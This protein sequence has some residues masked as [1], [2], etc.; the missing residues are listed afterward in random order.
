M[1]KL[2]G[3]VLAQESKEPLSGLKV[4]AY[5][6]DLLYD[7]LLG[8]AVT[9]EQGEFAM[10]FTEK[11]F[12]ELFESKPDIYL[13]IYSNTFEPIYDTSDCVRWGASESE[14]FEVLIPQDCLP[15][16]P[17]LSNDFVD[18]EILVTAKH[19][20][21]HDVNGYKVPKLP[22]FASDGQPG[23]PAL[24]SQHQ[25]IAMPMGTKAAKIEVT[26]G[27]PIIISGIRNPLPAQEPY[28]DLGSSKEEFE[29]GFTFEDF[30]PEF[31]PLSTAFRK[32]I[33]PEELVTLQTSEDFQLVHMASLKVQPVQYDANKKEYR[34]YPDLKYR[35]HLEADD[36]EEEKPSKREIGFHEAE[37]M[38]QVL[39]MDVVWRVEDLRIPPILIWEEAAHVIITDN[40]EWPESIA[41]ADGTTRAPNINERGVALVG[42][43]IAEYDRLAEWKTAKGMRSK[44]VTISQIVNGQFGDM[45]QNGLARDLQEVIRNFVKYAKSTWK[46]MYVL[47]AGDINVVP[48]RKLCGCSTYGTIGTGTTASNPPENGKCHIIPAK[49]TVKLWPKFTPAA[50]DPLA[51]RNGGLRIPYDSQAGSGR[52]GW[53][54]TTK[55]DF[56]TKDD[57]FE[58]RAANQPTAY[59]IVE[60][61][62]AVIDDSYY[63]LRD[64]NEIPSDFYY[65]SIIGPGYSQPGNHDF[66]LDNNGIYGQYHWS[67]GA[68]VSLDGIDLGSDVFVGRASTDSAAQATA[69][70]NKIIA[71]EKLEDANGVAI[72][73]DYLKKIIYSAALWG[74]WRAHFNQADTT[75]PP[76]EGRFTHE[77]G[78]TET[79]INLNFDVTLAG[80]NP[81]HRMVA[82]TANVDTVIDYDT[83]A[84]QNTLGWFYCTDNTYST[85]SA[86]A[87]RFL[88]IR[89][90]EAD[91]TPGSIVWDAIGMES[92]VVEKE[93]LRIRMN[94]WF[95]AFDQIDRHYDDYF[96]V[97]APPALQKRITANLKAAIDAGCHFLS[98][99]GHGWSGG[100]CG[101]NTNTQNYAN[102]NKFFIAYADS[103]STAR[104]DSNDS[105]AEALTI[106]PDGGAVCYVGNTRYSW[107]G[108]GDN[109]ERFFWAKTAAAGRPG[110]AAGLRQAMGGSRWWWAIYAQN[111]FGDPE[112]QA[113]T[114][115]PSTFTVTHPINANWNAGFDVNV[116]VNGVNKAN[117]KVTIMAG[118]KGGIATPEVIKSATTDNKGNVNLTLPKQGNRLA[119]TLHVTVAA[120]NHKPYTTTVPIN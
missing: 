108:I 100:C 114:K 38:N 83:T 99:T 78:T 4:R 36:K 91:I 95:P 107:I 5:D 22:G 23:E 10:E 98:L 116:K 103:C 61:P 6:K 104:I 11:D 97:A 44:L 85:Q 32:G 93:D 50:T 15:D 2:T 62:A 42:D 8:S 101:I 41:N 115:M 59:I 68:E 25:Y 37:L 35:V 86:A 16:T 65:A 90:P 7:D 40:F 79:H 33:Y 29:D 113:Y 27:E 26:L 56:E 70:V 52:L 12:S 39:N 63:W 110:I 112:M 77:G 34:F 55:D 96:D 80:G 53:Y 45:T 18:A 76:E 106:D 88:K 105:A 71:Y 82:R 73:T 102:N 92:S 19:I 47:M 60:G 30:E 46:T 21:I 118:W 75:I 117:A 9:N 3:R 111:F 31:T 43:M 1:Y 17:D 109:F 24:P 49:S 72:Q 64:V 74:K 89:G 67:N 87:T 58:R 14:H 54:F 120:A 51:T 13:A 66:D 94:S 57:G 119:N 84:N 48:I 69:F 20:E 81:S 28:P